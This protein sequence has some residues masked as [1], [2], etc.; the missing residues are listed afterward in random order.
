[1][2]VNAIARPSGETTGFT[3][4]VSRCGSVGSRTRC[5]IGYVVRCSETVAVKGI[6]DVA[7]VSDLRLMWP[8]AV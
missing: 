1:M 6:V 8:S 3:I 7:P 5:A 4:P 2:A